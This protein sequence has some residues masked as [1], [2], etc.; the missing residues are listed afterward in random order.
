MVCTKRRSQ[1]IMQGQMWPAKRSLSGDALSGDGFVERG[2]EVLELLKAKIVQ[3]QDLAVVEK[4]T[5]RDLNVVV[6][7]RLLAVSVVDGK[8]EVFVNEEAAL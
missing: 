4:V 7:K 6:Q 1:P 2:F 5:K 3:A 8:F